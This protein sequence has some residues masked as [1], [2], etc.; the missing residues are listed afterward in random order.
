[1]AHTF[2]D[3]R[4]VCPFFG[5]ILE[6]GEVDAIGCCAFYV[7]ILIDLCRPGVDASLVKIAGLLELYS[8]CIGMSCN[9]F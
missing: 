7:V 9:V 4:M 5:V 6:I 8:L 2:I 1:M 3:L